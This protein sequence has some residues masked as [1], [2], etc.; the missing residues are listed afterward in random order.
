MSDVVIKFQ[1]SAPNTWVVIHP[2]ERIPANNHLLLEDVRAWTLFN[3]KK[4]SFDRNYLTHW[5]LFTGFAGDLLMTVSYPEQL[6]VA[7]SHAMLGKKT[8]FIE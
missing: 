1:Y 4:E 6:F 5:A 8:I 7:I 3:Q 2:K